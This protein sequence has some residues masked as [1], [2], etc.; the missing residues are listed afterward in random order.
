MEPLPYAHLRYPPPWTEDLSHWKPMPVEFPPVLPANYPDQL[1]A[2]LDGV[3]VLK[4]YT[5]S[6]LKVL[7]WLGDALVE[8]A[9]YSSLYPSLDACDNPVRTAAPSTLR[10]KGFLGHIALWYELQHLNLYWQY[11]NQKTA[12]PS[13]ARMCHLFEALVGAAYF[14]AKPEPTM[15]WLRA[16]FDPWVHSL[17]RQTPIAFVGDRERELY[18]ARM[19]ARAGMPLPP[20]R[21]VQANYGPTFYCDPSLLSA[22]RSNSLSTVV[23]PAWMALDT[24]GVFLPDDYPPSPPLAG[25]DVTMALTE[26]DY[27]LHFGDHIRFNEGYR[28]LGERL[29]KAA[30]SILPIADVRKD[31]AAELD[32]IRMACL[33]LPVLATLGL[34]LDVH[35]HLRTVRANDDDSC[36]ISERQSANALSALAALTYVTVGKSTTPLEAVERSD[37]RQGWS[38]MVEWLVPLLTPWFS[39]AA[40]GNFFGHVGA[41]NHRRSRIEAVGAENLRRC[42]IEAEAVERRLDQI[43]GACRAQALGPTRTPKFKRGKGSKRK[44]KVRE[45]RG[46]RREGHSI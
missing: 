13:A 32:E 34:L 33:G 19:S 12:F 4:R 39:A 42:R 26:F 15:S 21:P 28:S 29:I 46:T 43:A 1:P 14:L 11:P 22:I 44:D 16:L 5:I 7:A 25:V 17:S 23:G 36:G 40:A 37:L 45:K 30:M 10:S 18:Q 38:G 2:G 31:V 41:E 8:A 6:E 3:S 9:L 27:H 24:S 35:R 20:L